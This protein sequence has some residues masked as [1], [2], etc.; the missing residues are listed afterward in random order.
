MMIG[1]FMVMEVCVFR[2]KCMFMVRCGV[3]RCSTGG[4]VAPVVTG[5]EE[6]MPPFV[7]PEQELPEQEPPPP[8][9]EA[10]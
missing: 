5:E 3:T 1:D 7:E 10:S 4:S 9:R 8:A 6:D 2:I